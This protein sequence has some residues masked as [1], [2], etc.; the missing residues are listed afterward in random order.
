MP[1]IGELPFQTRPRRESTVGSAERRRNRFMARNSDVWNL[2]RKTP[3]FTASGGQIADQG[4]GYI[5]LKAKV[6]MGKN[7]IR[8]NKTGGV[9]T[10][11]SLFA[12]GSRIKTGEKAPG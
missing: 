10:G 3:R 12:L 5:S 2:A 9:A 7:M 1:P 6:N 11:S 4:S 8:M